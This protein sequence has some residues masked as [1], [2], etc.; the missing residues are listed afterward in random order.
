M[1]RVQIFN[2]RG[3]MVEDLSKQWKGEVLSGV[4][5][6][7][8]GGVNRLLSSAAREDSGDP[9]RLE[10]ASVHSVDE[11]NRIDA[12]SYSTLASHNSP[13]GAVPV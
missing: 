10:V 5:R 9:S 6:D 2:F 11:Q 3:E 4:S 7:V 12:R 8:G 13:A 1:T